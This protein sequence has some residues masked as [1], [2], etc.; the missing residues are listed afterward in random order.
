MAVLKVQEKQRVI[1]GSIL[2]MIIVG[3]ITFAMLIIG[4]ATRLNAEPGIQTAVV[5]PFTLFELY[6]VPSATGGYNAGLSFRVGILYYSA[7]WLVI[8][9]FLAWFRLFSHKS[10]KDI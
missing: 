1:T 3:A 7:F 9:A 2:S 5:G 6:K 10:S 8:G 4:L